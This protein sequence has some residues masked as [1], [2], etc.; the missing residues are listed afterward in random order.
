MMRIFDSL[1]AWRQ[2]KL[3]WVERLVLNKVSS[4]L[5]LP[6][7][8]VFDV[9][10]SSINHVVRHPCGRETNFFI[11]KHGHPCLDERFRFTNREEFVLG[12][13]QTSSR[14]G[15]LDVRAE[16]SI[17]EGLIFSI[18]FDKKPDA[19]F[20][21]SEDI[22]C[23]VAIHCVPGVASSE[24]PI[25]SG[26]TVTYVVNSRLPKEY[27]DLLLSGSVAPINGWV[28]VKGSRIRKLVHEAGNFYVIAERDQVGALAVREGEDTGAVYFMNLADGRIERTSGGIISFIQ[29]K[30]F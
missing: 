17:V 12:T 10:V 27:I 3:S 15:N 5:P 18:A 7:R 19:A 16:V 28:I 30:Q 23:D 11:L 25:A 1:L 20:L 4:N 24:V 26:K 22:V 8:E 6:A 21:N 29:G 14:N 13:V 2:Q 9:Q